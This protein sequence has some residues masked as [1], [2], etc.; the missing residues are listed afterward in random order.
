LA[1]RKMRPNTILV[2]VSCTHVN[3]MCAQYKKPAKVSL[4]RVSRSGG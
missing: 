3:G 4:S 2:R 1:A